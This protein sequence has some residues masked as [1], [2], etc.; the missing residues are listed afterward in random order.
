MRKIPVYIC[1]RKRC[2]N[3]TC[4]V[5]HNTTDITFAE[6]DENGEPVR[7]GQI[8]TDEERCNLINKDFKFEDAF[9]KEMVYQ[10]ALLLLEFF[11]HKQDAVYY[12]LT[13]QEYD[14][15]LRLSMSV[16]Y[17]ILRM[18]YGMKR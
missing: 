10:D 1:N 7:A 15:A 11:W 13:K 5:C 3:G 9:S 12:T 2:E 8:S 17:E 6:K 16:K 4:D 14:T 18:E